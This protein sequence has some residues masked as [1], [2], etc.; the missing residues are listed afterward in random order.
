MPAHAPAVSPPIQRIAVG[1]VVQD[2][3]HLLRQFRKGDVQ[4]MAHLR[5]Y[6]RRDML[7]EVN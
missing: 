1:N 3:R 4:R 2:P 6:S 7:E 5:C